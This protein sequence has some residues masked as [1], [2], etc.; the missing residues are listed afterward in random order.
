MIKAVNVNYAPSGAPS[1]FGETK[2]PTLIY[3]TI[4]FVEIEY[5]LSEDFGGDTAKGLNGDLQEIGESLFDQFTDALGFGGD[6]E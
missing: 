5:F 3:L 6:D 4:E 2:E 1:Y